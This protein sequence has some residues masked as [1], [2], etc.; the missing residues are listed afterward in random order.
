MEHFVNFLIPEA[1]EFSYLV[2]TGRGDLS[3]L[4]TGPKRES[5]FQANTQ[6]KK[7]KNCFGVYGSI[8]DESGHADH[9]EYGMKLTRSK[10]WGWTWK[11]IKL[12]ECNL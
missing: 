6:K 12:K 5:S 2:F 1:T 8:V 4:S 3:H 9:I 10:L 11:L 7:K